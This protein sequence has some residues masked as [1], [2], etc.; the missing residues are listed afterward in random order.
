[1]AKR[2]YVANRGSN[3]VSVIKAD[4]L[5]SDIRASTVPSD[6][7]MRKWT[8]IPT[9]LAKDC[10]RTRYEVLWVQRRRRSQLFGRSDLRL[11][12]SYQ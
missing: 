10:Q 9:F 12:D 8:K 1:M 6:G 4:C 5:G 3:N 11:R 7:S 2:A